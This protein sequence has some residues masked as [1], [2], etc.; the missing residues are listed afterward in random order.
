MVLA[1]MLPGLT[2]Q[3]E[4]LQTW[5]RPRVGGRVAGRKSGQNVLSRTSDLQD[6]DSS[7]Y[8]TLRYASGHRKNSFSGSNIQC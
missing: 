2:G 6:T 4:P 1:R 8:G 5:G 3:E 7:S